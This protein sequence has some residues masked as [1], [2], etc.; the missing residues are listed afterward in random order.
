MGQMRRSA[1]SETESQ[2]EVQ[3]V[4]F[5]LE[6][7]KQ[8]VHFCVNSHCRSHIPISQCV[9]LTMFVLLKLIRLREIVVL[10]GVY[11]KL[12]MK[13]PA[14]DWCSLWDLCIYSAH[15]PPSLCILHWQMATGSVTLRRVSVAGTWETFRLSTGQFPIRPASLSQTRLGDQGEITLATQP[16]VNR[17]SSNLPL[18]LLFLFRPWLQ[19]QV[20]VQ[21]QI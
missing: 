7:S 12:T 2:K 5:V 18:E 1:V 19:I 10:C 20:Q 15:L 14:Q 21:V 9:A 13:L 6:M 16:Q 8:A 11:L 3:D 4:V 17:L